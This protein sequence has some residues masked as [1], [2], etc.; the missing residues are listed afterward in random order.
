MLIFISLVVLYRRAFYP[1]YFYTRN[2]LF[3]TYYSCLCVPHP[4]PHSLWVKCLYIVRS[5]VFC[6]Q[7]LK[8]LNFFFTKRGHTRSIPYN[9]YHKI[10]IFFKDSLSDGFIENLIYC[11]HWAATKSIEK[12]PISNSVNWSKG[13]WPLNL[14]AVSSSSKF[15]CISLFYGG[16]WYPCFGLLVTSPLGFKARAGSLICT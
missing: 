11:S 14:V 15:E 5:P 8:P 16:H 1:P 6:V 12:N 4:L 13:R 2:C 10:F 7:F 3:V 9:T